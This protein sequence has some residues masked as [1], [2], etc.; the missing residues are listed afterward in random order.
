MLEKMR[1]IRIY[2]FIDFTRL[3]SRAESLSFDETN[4]ERDSVVGV[5]AL[6]EQA[7]QLL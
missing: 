4:Y 5:A 2:W 1:M 3:T 6:F 7:L